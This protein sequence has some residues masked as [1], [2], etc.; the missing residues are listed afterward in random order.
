MEV[1][2]LEE[3]VLLRTVIGFLGEQEQH[4]WWSSSFFGAGSK[5]FLSPVFPRTHVLAQYQGVLKAAS[6]VHDERIGV[7]N[8]FH[9]F[10][11]PEDLE[12]SIQ[13]T[14]QSPHMI[15]AITDCTVNSKTALAKLGKISDGL[16]RNDIGP[17]SVGS[18]ANIRIAAL[19]R[20]VAAYYATGL[21]DHFEV[22]PYFVK[23]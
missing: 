13:R 14:I 21:Q 22:Y 10:R 2:E 6:I 19:W 3:L 12:Q 4:S 11:L 16:S 18:F 15:L 1:K 9:L 7:G 17:V 23:Q 5:S 20:Q 8:V